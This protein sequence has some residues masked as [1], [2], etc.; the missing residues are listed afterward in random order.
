MWILFSNP[1]HHV[2]FTQ[3]N[4]YWI[5]FF[6]FFLHPCLSTHYIFFLQRMQQSP[7]ISFVLVVYAP[8]ST[9]YFLSTKPDK[10]HTQYK[11]LYWQCLHCERA[12]RKLYPLFSMTDVTTTPTDAAFVSSLEPSWELSARS[13]RRAM[14][15]LKNQRFFCVCFVCFCL[16]FLLVERAWLAGF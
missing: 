13:L 5:F 4:T 6:C 11:P 10:T 12:Y 8:F 15:R 2:I 16:V 7:V 1:C 14:R 3:K 9:W